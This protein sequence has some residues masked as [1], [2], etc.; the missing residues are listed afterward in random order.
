[1]FQQIKGPR[2][3][4]RFAA[5]ILN[6]QQRFVKKIRSKEKRHTIRA[7]RKIRPRAGEICH[8]YTG[9]RTKKAKLLGRWL[10]VKASHVPGSNQ[11]KEL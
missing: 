2:Q 3:E 5:V 9:L 4:R 7:R 11:H 6:F 10:C 8:C 1:M